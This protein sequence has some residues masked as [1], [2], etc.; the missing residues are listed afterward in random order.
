V[1]QGKG[2]APRPKS[3]PEAEYADR[4]AATF[5]DPRE[6]LRRRNIQQARDALD[7]AGVPPYVLPCTEDWPR[8]EALP[9]TDP[10]E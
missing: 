1:T 8:R 6:A 10:P 4:W 2:S 7:R 9:T 3:I 5:G